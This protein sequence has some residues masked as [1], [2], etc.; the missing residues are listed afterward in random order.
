MTSNLTLKSGWRFEDFHGHILK[1]S[2]IDPV[3]LSDI[4]LSNR[5]QVRLRDKQ[6]FRWILA[7]VAVCKECDFFVRYPCE[8]DDSLYL[9]SKYSTWNWRYWFS[10]GWWPLCIITLYTK[11]AGVSKSKEK[12]QDLLIFFKYFISFD[13]QMF[14]LFLS[15]DIF[16]RSADSCIPNFD[17]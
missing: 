12:V 5:G 4:C 2:V 13:P 1:H 7:D 16:K 17:P 14:S 15:L 8:G 11:I 9:V 3:M 10:D 6:E